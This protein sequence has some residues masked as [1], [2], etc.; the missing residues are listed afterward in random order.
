MA[1]NQ[2]SSPASSPVTERTELAEHAEAW[3][4]FILANILWA[5]CSL[6]VI[7][8]PAATAGLFAFISARSRGKQPDLFLV[9]FAGMRQHWRKATL[10]ALLDLIGGGLIGANILILSQ[11]NI[12]AD[13][14]AF[15]SRSVTLFAALALLLLNLYV[16]HLLVLL[17][18]WTTG[19]LIRAAMRL[20]FVYPLWSISVLLAV[21]V[22]F[23]ISLLLPQGSFVLATAAVMTWI[24]CRGTWRVIQKHLAP[25]A[26]EAR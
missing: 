21:L 24:T 15:L 11:M 17:E 13:P 12:N 8:L 7:T 4:T 5:L 1:T 14:V 18:T 19:Q 20:V 26:D 3:S 6:P 9:F 22:M 23:G 10:I 25:A 16:W 2:L